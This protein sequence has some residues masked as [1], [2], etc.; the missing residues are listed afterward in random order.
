MK[1]T[2]NILDSI[3]RRKHVSAYNFTKERW[4]H[5]AIIKKL[6]GQDLRPGWSVYFDENRVVQVPN[7]SD[8]VISDILTF[9]ENDIS[10]KHVG[11]IMFI[12]PDDDENNKKFTKLLSDRFGECKKFAFFD[13][14]FERDEFNFPESFL[15]KK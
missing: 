6:L 13:S 12:F 15:K 1:Q 5:Y 14:S 4:A 7:Y 11:V 10:D 3:D 9:I 2:I 8:R